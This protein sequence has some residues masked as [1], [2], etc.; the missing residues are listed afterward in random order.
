MPGG[1]TRRGV[2]ALG[3]ACLATGAGAVGL[4]ALPLHRCDDFLHSVGVNTHFGHV[5]TPYETRFERCAAALDELGIR[6]LR[7]DVNFTQP[8]PPPQF[9]RIA[10]LAREGYRFSLIF[11]DGLGVAPV[12]P[13]R[14]LADIAAWSAGGIEIA[15]G[16][17][18]PDI[19][20]RASAVST[21][22]DH[23]RALY[24]AARAGGGTVRVA[25]PSYIFGSVAA[26]EDLSGAVDFANIHCYP[27]MEHPETTGAG[28]LRKFMAAARPVFG[29]APILATENGYHT[30]LPTKSSHLPV[31]EAIRA[32]YMPR[33]LMWS[34]LQGVRRT[35]I[36]ELI[37]ALD[38]GEAD[39]D[40][41]FGLLRHDGTATPAFGAVRALMQLFR[42]A[43]P[44]T[45]EP[46]EAAVEGAPDLHACR[47]SRGDGATLVPLWLGVPGWDPGRRRALAD[48][49]ERPVAVA[50]SRV[51]ASV[52]LHRFGDDG[53]VAT[54]A[55]AP[56]GRIVVGA[57]DRLTVLE[58]RSA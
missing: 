50:L 55:L 9:A 21:S 27:G 15:E 30:A 24:R 33:L 19:A 2:L 52:R 53:S 7:E 28:E 14:R 57:T 34:F 39:P 43:G 49:P 38:G 45:A 5:G 42:A 6:H 8:E 35:Y 16:S 40:S 22:A 51:P 36:Y 32:R 56:A 31:S 46:F 1:P 17:N 11:Y 26:A 37:C 58:L 18:E 44:G 47:F 41:H 4:P 12:T 10:R 48:R 13:P 20:G 54:T 23:Q 29:S 25:G 3:A